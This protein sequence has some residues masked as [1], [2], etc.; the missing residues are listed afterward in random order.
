[1]GLGFFLL[2]SFLLSLEL[3]TNL[4]F[5]SAVLPNCES[6]VLNLTT[7]SLYADVKDVRSSP[8]LFQKACITCSVK[9][10][11]WPEEALVV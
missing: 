9:P 6:K 3:G 7:E 11:S 4:K 1:M 8:N 2:F 10:A 5:G